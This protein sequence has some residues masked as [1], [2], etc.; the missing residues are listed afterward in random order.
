MVVSVSLSVN[1]QP[2]KDQVEPRLLLVHY[3][4]DRLGLTGTKIA[5]DTSQSCI[6]GISRQL[7][8]MMWSGRKAAGACEYRVP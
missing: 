8:L 7:D 2:Y 6:A 5:C 1:G 4:R 3:L